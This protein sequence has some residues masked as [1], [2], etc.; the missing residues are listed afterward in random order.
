MVTWVEQRE[1]LERLE[2][3]VQL[4]RMLAERN[5][6]A[7]DCDLA[8]SLWALSPLR[9]DIDDIEEALA[10]I[11]ECTDLYEK[12]AEKNPNA[13]NQCFSGALVEMLWCLISRREMRLD[14]R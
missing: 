10:A 13:F 1:A 7:F 5:P 11:Q 9:F 4:C 12:L 2:E 3:D 6:D 8:H 14:E